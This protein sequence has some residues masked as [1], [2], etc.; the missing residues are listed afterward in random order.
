MSKFIRNVIN[1]F[2]VVTGSK[3][4][5][6]MVLVVRSDLQ[7]SKGKIGAQCAHAAIICHEEAHRKRPD[8]LNAWLATGQPKVVVQ[9]NSM[10][11]I[12]ALAKAAQ[13]K[14]IVNGMVRDAGRTQ[15]AAGTV[16][17]LGLGPDS[18][19]NIDSLTKSLRLL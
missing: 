1:R 6:K 19:S 14:N 8:L 13:E 15:V 3:E 4:P 2:Q 9:V 17:V 5:T 18:V 11:R 12:E 16:T 7:M 10:Q